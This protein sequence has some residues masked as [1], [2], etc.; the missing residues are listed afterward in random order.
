M[1]KTVVHWHSTSVSDTIFSLEGSYMWSG[2]WESTLVQWSL[3]NTD[4]KDFV[5]RLGAA[6]VRLSM[7]YDGHVLAVSH[8]DSGKFLWRYANINSW[9]IMFFYDFPVIHLVGL[10]RNIL[11]T[12]KS[13]SLTAADLPSN[14]RSE[15]TD[16][17]FCV[18][19]I[20]RCLVLRGKPGSLQFYNPSKDRLES[21]VF[22]LPD[23]KMH[24]W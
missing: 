19:P 5:S 20:S 24:M 6:I 18:D 16:G 23:G 22:H 1:S 10:Q 9:S 14:Y 11:Q 17:V 8:S 21:E 7:S 12:I 2:G 13:I 4:Q 3:N 15:Q